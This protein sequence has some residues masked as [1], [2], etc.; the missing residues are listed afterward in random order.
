MATSPL[1]IITSFLVCIAARIRGIGDLYAEC[2]EQT[3]SGIQF[4]RDQMSK[5]LWNT[6]MLVMCALLG[7]LVGY[8]QIAIPA[9]GNINTIAGNGTQGDTNNGGL[10]TGAEIGIPALGTDSAGNVFLTEY[11]YEEVRKITAATGDI[12]IFAGSGVAGY[13]GNGGSATAADLNFPLAPVADSSG[14]IYFV[15]AKNNVI[16]EVTASTGDI[17]AIWTGNFKITASG[18]TGGITIDSS[19]NLYAWTGAQYKIYKIA[20]GTWTTTTIAG[21]GTKGDTGDGGSA[22]SAGIYPT[23]LAVDSSGNVYFCAP[24]Y[25]V[26]RMISASTGNISVVA[27]TGTAGDTGDGGPA[28]SAKINGPYTIAIDKVNNLYIT[29]E[30]G[31]RV[32]KVTAATGNISTVAGNGTTGFSGD[33]GLATSAEFN[34]PFSIAVDNAGNLYI[35]DTNNFRIRVVAQTQTTPTITWGTPAAIAYGTAL[36][37]TQLDATASVAGTFAYTPGSGTVLTPG[38]QTLSVT[39]TPTDTIDYSTATASVSIEANKVTSSLSVFCSP[40]PIT[41]GGANSICM[42]T[43]IGSSPT[44]TV[45]LTINGSAW[46]TVTLSGGAATAQLSSTYGLGT[47]TIGGTYNG[48]TYNSTATGS[49]SVTVNKATPTVSTWP[50]GST[51]TYGQSLASSSLSGGSAS[52]D[53]SFSWNSSGTVP[54]A[55]TSSQG[56]TFTPADTTDYNTPAPGTASVTVA[57]A[58]PAVTTWPTATGIIYGQTL[59]SSTLSGGS[60]SIGGTFAWTAPSTAPGVGTAAQS[61]TF[62]PTDT[63]DYNT[64]ATGTASVT[65]A[66]AGSTISVATSGTPSTF[67]GAVTFTATTSAGATGTVTFYDGGSS[68]GTGTISGTTATLAISTLT[69]GSHTITASWPGNTNYNAATSTGISQVVNKATPTVT[70]WP[71]ATSIT[72]GQT[73]ASS[74]LSGGSASVGGTFAWTTPTTAPGVGTAAQSVTFTPTDTTDYNTPATGTASVTLAKAASTISVATSGTPSTY[75]GSVTFTATTS[76]GATGTATFFD[77][78]SSIGTGTISGTSATLAISTLTGGSHTI[79]A[80]WPGNTNYSSA[81]SPGITQVVNAAA[82]TITFTAPATPVTYGVAPISLVASS[83]SGLGVTFTV[84]SGPATVAGST[85]TVTGAGTVV[86]A[87]NQA[88]NGNYSAAVQVTQIITVNQASSTISVATSGSS[89]IYGGLVTFTATVSA[90]ATGTVTFYDGGSS[91]GTGTISGTTATLAISTLT[92]GAH[93]I[94]AGWSG[95]PNYAEATSTSIQQTVNRSSVTINSASSLVTSVYG[96]YVVWTF[97][98]SGSGVTPTG[99]L[100]VSDVANTLATVPINAGIATYSSAVLTAGTHAINTVYSG[101]GN[102]R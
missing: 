55:G 22:L 36:S 8:G 12:S 25:H 7:E 89:S 4:W 13:T 26:V 43:V 58:T 95:N 51:I 19:G 62:T 81:T 101:D 40:N 42:A 31:N 61:V 46:T 67:A 96:D 14:N 28:T 11:L 15:D 59:A 79:T 32:R 94:T 71:T 80:S 69:G 1:G 52:V 60:G 70:A 23:S 27:G 10:A 91:I 9:H 45:T 3:V 92:G 54:G 63:T 98:V 29:E 93:T 34:V 77:G 53:G 48:D 72:Y 35:D 97:T 17:N 20:A 44:G 16:R 88:G 33:G 99:S 5:V 76:A 102:Y 85:L 66:K 30:N 50:T 90:G 38:A 100:T 18:Y 56:V 65:V 6:A 49:G 68:I 83:S 37:G 82:Q 78:G 21:T 64:P 75:G 73:L 24:T 39:F 87:A 47:Y 86:V 57:K 84:I 2:V 41:Y 74:T